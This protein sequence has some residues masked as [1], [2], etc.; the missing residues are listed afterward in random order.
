[1]TAN[2]PRPVALVTGASSGL[3]HAYARQLAEGGWDLV[4]VARRS[5]RLEA[6][7]ARLGGTGGVS[8]LPLVADLTDPE[9]LG[10][11]EERIGRGVDLVVNCAGFAGYMPF[12]QLPAQVADGLVDVHVRTVAR[13]TRAAVGV[14]LPAGRGAIINVASLLAFSESAVLGRFNRAMYAG[15]KAFIVTFTQLVAQEVAAHGLRVQVCCPGAVVTE[16]HDVAGV[17]RPPAAMSPEEV[18]TA[19]LRALDRG[20]VVC[21]PGLDDPTVVDRYHE[22]QREMLRQGNRPQLAERYRV[23]AG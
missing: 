5:D 22:A 9:G 1:M 10:A 12:A 13:L 19:S 6:L 18:V 16:F 17:P 4:P 11:V 14:M 3:G 2:A 8:V 23:A 15:C 7:A 20:E 21:V